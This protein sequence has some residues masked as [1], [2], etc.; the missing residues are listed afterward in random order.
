[1]F[2]HALFLKKLFSMSCRNKF[3]LERKLELIMHHISQKQWEKQSWRE[4][5][6]NID[7]SNLNSEKLEGLQTPNKFL[8]YT[9]QKGKKSI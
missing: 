6:Y 9:I 4:H 7:A 1:M 8:Q 5:T 3:R 2:Y